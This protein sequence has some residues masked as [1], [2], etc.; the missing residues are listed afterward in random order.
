MKWEKNGGN[1]F[2]ASFFSEYR[3]I[4]WFLCVVTFCYG[5]KSGRDVF[6]YLRLLR[7]S[8][9]LDNFLLKDWCKAPWFTIVD[10]EKLFNNLNINGKP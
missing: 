2:T 10:H 6:S 9:R 5:R 4:G 3:E 1:S 8:P 7:F